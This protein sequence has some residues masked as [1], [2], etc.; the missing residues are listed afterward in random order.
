MIEAEK[1]I[2]KFWSQIP[3]ILEPGKKIPK[4]IAKIFKKIKKLNYS[5]IFSQNGMI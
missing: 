4:K 1:E 2:K 3:F 5:I